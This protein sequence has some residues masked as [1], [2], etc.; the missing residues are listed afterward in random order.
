MSNQPPREQVLVEPDPRDQSLFDWLEDLFYGPMECPAKLVVSPVR[1]RNFNDLGDPILTRVYLPEG[2]DKE[3]VAEGPK[4]SDKQKLKGKPTKE[5]LVV[6]SNQILER[7]Q[8]DC[9]E[10]GRKQRYGVH[11]WHLM[12]D[13]QPYSR[14]LKMMHPNRR[15]RNEEYRDDSDE[16]FSPHIGYVKQALHHDEQMQTLNHEMA[17]A[18]LDRSNRENEYLHR[19]LDNMHQKLAEANERLA[20]ALSLEHER[21]LELQW[22]QFKQESFAQGRDIVFGLAPTII[23]QL[24]GRKIAEVQQ[25]PESM[26]LKQFFKPVD[27]GG[28]LTEDQMNK[29]FSYVDASNNSI[30]SGVLSIEQSDVLLSVAFKNGS[31]DLLDKIL[32]GGSLGVTQDQ[33]DRLREIFPIAQLAPLLAM[34]QQRIANKTQS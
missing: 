27:E 25:T 34:I 9:N 14:F 4:A 12:R 29:A 30:H 18:L 2:G 28:S 17:C 31:P 11:A 1:G 15:P 6:L 22:T 19:Q 26:A 21:K 32:P 33:I 8:H 10:G 16:D 3:P 20:A 7:M 13:S 23:N 24:S 5:Q